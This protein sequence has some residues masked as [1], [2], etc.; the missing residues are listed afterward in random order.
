MIKGWS[1]GDQRVI[2]GWSRGD[3][4]SATCIPTQVGEVPMW[5]CTHTLSL[6][7]SYV[8]KVRFTYHIENIFGQGSNCFTRPFVITNEG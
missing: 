1:R 7:I 4:R 6:L 3:K 5:H 8:T 2:R